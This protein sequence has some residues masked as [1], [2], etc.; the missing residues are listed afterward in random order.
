MIGF[1]RVESRSRMILET[2]RLMLN[3][4]QTSDW[5]AL[6]PIATDTEVMRYITGGIPWT[7]DRIQ[8]FV[9]KQV[10][11]HSERGFCRWKLLTKPAREMIGFCGVGF[12]R[13]EAE[14]E[15]GWWIARGHWG[16]GLATE[17]AQ[18]ALRDAFE[19]VELKRIISVARPENTASV[20][21]MQKLGLEL[22]CGFESEGIRLLRYSIDQSRYPASGRLT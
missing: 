13:D 5:T 18:C 17:A 12:W 22:E 10:Q 3:T 8:S 4:W 19:R 9:E 20:R 21:I 6:R 16:H 2:E 14:P 7:E 1:K 15:I 11:L